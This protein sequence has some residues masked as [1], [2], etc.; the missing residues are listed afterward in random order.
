MKRAKEF[1]EIHASRPLCLVFLLQTETSAC[2]NTAVSSPLLIWE[3]DPARK[4]AAN[5]YDI[6]HRCVYSE[7]LLMIYRGTVRNTYFYSKN[8]F[9]KLAHLV[10]I[11]IGHSWFYCQ[12][13]KN[14]TWTKVSSLFKIHYP[15]SYQDP[16]KW[17]CL[18]FHVTSSG[19]HHVVIDCRE[20][21]VTARGP[22]QAAYHHI[23]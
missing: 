15:A 18:C 22:Q 6:H 11:I 12:I 16:W 8:K 4:L 13:H 5:L 9:E 17:P 10:G 1:D 2:D 19:A 21:K 3:H 7:K 23:K 14:N 20:L